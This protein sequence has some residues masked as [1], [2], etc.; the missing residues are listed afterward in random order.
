MERAWVRGGGG[1][2]RRGESLRNLAPNVLYFFAS[3]CEKVLDAAV[4][5][6]WGVVPTERKRFA[7]THR[8]RSPG[9]GLTLG[10]ATCSGT[11]Q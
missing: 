7:A 2:K 8:E 4:G 11:N 9:K 10:F 1:R 3:W 6:L 5:E